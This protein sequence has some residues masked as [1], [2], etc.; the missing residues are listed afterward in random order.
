MATMGG[1]AIKDALAKLSLPDLKRDLEDTIA[2]TR[3]KQKRHDA[4]KR[5]W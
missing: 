5:L 3:S 4:L 1:E 2:N